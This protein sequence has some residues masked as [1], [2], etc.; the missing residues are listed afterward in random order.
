MKLDELHPVDAPT[1]THTGPVIVAPAGTVALMLV[2]E[3]TVKPP[4]STVTP[5]N[6]T[7]LAPVSPEPVISTG[8]P[9]DPDVGLKPNTDGPDEP[10]PQPTLPV[11]R[12]VPVVVLNAQVRPV[13]VPPPAE[14]LSVKR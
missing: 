4:A 8:V 3:F 6:V 2:S 12:T 5:P 14:P 9:G 13:A 1:V 7:L 10:P 11:R